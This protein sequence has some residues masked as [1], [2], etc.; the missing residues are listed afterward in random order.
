MKNYIYFNPNPKRTRVGDCTIRA[1]SKV[2]GKSWEDVYWDLCNE[3]FDQA[4]MPSSNSVWGRYLRNHGYEKRIVPDTCPN[5]YT[6]STLA[7]ELPKGRY[8]FALDGHVVAV[9]NGCYFDTWDSGNEIPLYYW[10]KRS[11]ES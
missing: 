2:L 5:C 3:G 1:I 6:V 4:D 8:V 10:Q 11:N 9:V 7:E